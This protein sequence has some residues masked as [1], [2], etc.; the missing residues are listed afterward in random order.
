MSDI[1]L[2]KLVMTQRERELRAERKWSPVDFV[3]MPLGASLLVVM[4]SLAIV[5]S[6]AGSIIRLSLRA[7]PAG[8]GRARKAA[9]VK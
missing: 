1:A 3:A 2:A 8:A 5:A 9:R 7:I 6:I 4:A